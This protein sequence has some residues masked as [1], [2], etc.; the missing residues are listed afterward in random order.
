MGDAKDQMVTGLE[1]YSLERAGYFVRRAA[2]DPERTA[3]RMGSGLTCSRA[4]FDL[5]GDLASFNAISADLLP[6]GRVTQAGMIYE[7]AIRSRKWLRDIDVDPR[8]PAAD[9][10]CALLSGPPAYGFRLA[11]RPEC[12]L[13]VVPGSH[14]APLSDEQASSLVGCARGIP[15]AVLVRLEPGDLLCYHANLLRYDG[16]ISG[17]CLEIQF[18]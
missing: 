12:G 5:V 7:E 9:Q 14:A 2:V 10:I 18:S 1:Q 11:V 3:A 13:L 4:G 6:S 17:R 8:L 16:P 15:G